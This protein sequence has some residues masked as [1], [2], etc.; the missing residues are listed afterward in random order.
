MWHLCLRVA[1]KYQGW[2]LVFCVTNRCTWCHEACSLDCWSSDNLSWSVMLD[3]ISTVFCYE[4]QKCFHLC[5][6]KYFPPIPWTHSQCPNLVGL[7]TQL[8]FCIHCLASKPSV[9]SR[10]NGHPA[11]SA[12]SMLWLYV[13]H[14]TSFPPWP[15]WWCWHQ[16]TV[17]LVPRSHKL[18][19]QWD[20]CILIFTGTAC[21]VS[22]TTLE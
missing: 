14:S 3:R 22:G 11:S 7:S 19:L 1:Q 5:L 10:C 15:W 16:A 20:T 6:S 2:T 21:A 13:L 4:F 8:C 17:L 18:W 9:W 12:H